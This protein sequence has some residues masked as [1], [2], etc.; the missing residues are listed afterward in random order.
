MEQYIKKLEVIV[1]Y[2]IYILLVTSCKKNDSSLPP[3]KDIEGNSYKVVTIG[4]QVW[5][6]ENLKTT[7][8]ND[9]ILIPVTYYFKD[10]AYK[11]TYG[12]LY[13]IDVLKNGNLCPTGWHVPT[14]D[15]WVNLFD[16][17]GGIQVAG[18]ERKEKGTVHWKLP[19]NVRAKDSYGFTALPGGH[20]NYQPAFNPPYYTYSLVFLGERGYWWS[21]TN[22]SPDNLPAYFMSYG[23]SAVYKVSIPLDFYSVRCIKDN[24]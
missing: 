4:S 15:E 18:R 11:Y 7:T 2:V 23:D 24:Y 9:G 14:D 5:R 19:N 17:A 20:L 6:A 10:S 12:I 22:N 1:V 8:Y 16:F 13:K 3:V 21:M